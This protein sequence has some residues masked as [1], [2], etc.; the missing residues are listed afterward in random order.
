MKKLI[1]VLLTVFLN[2]F[3]TSCSINDH[4]LISEEIENAQNTGGDDEAEILP[5]PP[6]PPPTTGGN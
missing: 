6:P 3:L 4:E 5:P 2:L 1:I